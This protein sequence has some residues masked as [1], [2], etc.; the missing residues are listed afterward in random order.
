[1]DNRCIQAVCKQKL[2]R[3]SGAYGLEGVLF[4]RKAWTE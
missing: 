2:D 3:D 1:M 4:F